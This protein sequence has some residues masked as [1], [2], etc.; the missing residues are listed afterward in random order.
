LIP[1]P[2]LAPFSGHERREVGTHTI[3]SVPELSL[4]E[5]AARV[6]GVVVR[7]PG[8]NAVIQAPNPGEPE[9][10]EQADLALELLRAVLQQVGAP[11]AVLEALTTL[12][13]SL[14]WVIK[15]KSD[16]LL[17]LAAKILELQASLQKEEFSRRGS[18]RV[19]KNSGAREK[20]EAKKAAES[21]WNEWMDRK[22]KH[23]WR[24]EDFAA[25]ALRRWPGKIASIGVVVGWIPAWKRARAAKIEAAS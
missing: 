11:K 20:A 5:V 23:T 22:P 25:E 9:A 18:L 3:V 6:G 15:S 10:M 17:K 4:E 21:L 2:V 13:E 1:N 7:G 12:D 24:N 16:E 8:R 14:R 19:T